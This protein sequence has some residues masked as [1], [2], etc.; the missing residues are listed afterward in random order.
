LI[1]KTISKNGVHEEEEEATAVKKTLLHVWSSQ[2]CTWVFHNATGKI[3]CGQIKLK[4]SWLEGSNNTMC[5]EKK[6]QHTN[7]KTSS[8]L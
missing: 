5:G 1:R 4:F 7:I 6:A 3:F 8:Q 2:K